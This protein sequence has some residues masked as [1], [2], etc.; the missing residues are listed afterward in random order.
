MHFLYIL[1]SP[2]KDQ[3]FV[4]ETNNVPE[5]LKLHNSN[6]FLKFFTRAATDWRLKRIISCSSKKEILKLKKRLTKMKSRNYI[7]QV[8]D[9]PEIL[10]E[11]PFAK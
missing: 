6:K 7:E 5:R 8:I 2:K 3:Y 10:K 9:Q 4:G 11:I 1:Y